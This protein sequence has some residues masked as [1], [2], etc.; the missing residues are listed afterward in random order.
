MGNVVALS[1]YRNRRAAEEHVRALVLFECAAHLARQN[2]A[3]LNALV[4]EVF[5]A[6]WVEQRIVETLSRPRREEAVVPARPRRA[7]RRAR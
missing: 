4:D 7:A 1:N 2:H 3:G 6:G 5:G